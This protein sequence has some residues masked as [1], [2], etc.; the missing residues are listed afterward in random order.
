MPSSKFI[1]LTFIFSSTTAID[2]TQKCVNEA[3]Q[4]ATLEDLCVTFTD[5]CDQ[6][7]DTAQGHEMGCMAGNEFNMQQTNCDCDAPKQSDPMTAK[8][9]QDAHDA[10][11]GGADPCTTF[12]QCC[13]RNCGQKGEKGSQCL[14]NNFRIDL[15]YAYCYCGDHKNDGGRAVISWTGLALCAMLFMMT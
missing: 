11:N 7:C 10:T 2:F 3:I 12:R 4:N 5:C 15:S 14:A 1:I 8:C 6:S 9:A 13:D